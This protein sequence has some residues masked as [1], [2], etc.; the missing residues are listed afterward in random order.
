MADISTTIST[1]LSTTGVFT[2]DLAAFQSEYLW[3]VI[4][5]F[6][7]AFT[8]GAGMGAN[9]VSN[10]FGT[11]VGSRVLS[12]V[13]AY[14]LATIMESL[15]AILLG[16]NVADT[17]RKGVVDINLYADDPRALMLGQIA[18]LGAG[19]CWLLIATM[20]KLPVSTTHSIVGATIGFSFMLKGTEGIQWKKVGEIGKFYFSFYTIFIILNCIFILTI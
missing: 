9:D 3:A 5:A 1:L 16:Y 15:G 12:I 10:A 20:C 8:L 4:V 14:I 17:M 2:M 6:I 19:T 7:L 13:Q 18:I 11:S